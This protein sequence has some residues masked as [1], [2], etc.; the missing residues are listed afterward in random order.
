MTAAN[1][2]PKRTGIT[3]YF[4][5]TT[6]SVALC[7]GIAV[8]G[9]AQP[10]ALVGASDALTSFSLRSLDWFFLLTCSLF[11]FVCFFLA[12]SRYGRLK[13]GPD[14]SKPE[15]STASWIAMLFAAGMGAGL[16]FWGVAEPV[17]H[18]I[19]PPNAVDPFTPAAARQAMVLANLHWGLHAWGVYAMAAL[20]LAYFGFRRG[21]PLLV[22][23]PIRAAFSP[24][25]GR[26]VGGLAEV[27]AILSVAFGVAASL[28]MGVLQVSSGLNQVFG[29]PAR[30]LTVWLIVLAVAVICYM[31]SAAT[32]VGKGIKILSNTNMILA[33]VLLLFILFAGP[34]PFLLSTFITS[35]GDYISSFVSLSFRLNAYSGSVEWSRVWTLTYL[36][37]WIAWGPFVGVFVARIS[38]GRT[39]REFLLGVVFVPSLASALWFSVFG[40]SGLYVEL[41]GGGGI[42]SLVVEDVSTALYGLFD[43]FPLT[44][45]LSVLALV[46]VFIFLVTSADSASFVLGMMSSGGEANPSTGI[47][48]FWG[49]V[50]AV[51][52]AA[53]LIAGAGVDLMKALAITGAI[54]FVFIMVIQMI[55]L[56]RALGEEK[57]ERPG[58]TAEKEGAS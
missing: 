43:F 5:I 22:S 28:G 45:G 31:A 48:L 1:E 55:I 53:A 16:L 32:G 19:S 12:A 54:P 20:V 18:F 42:A 13:L 17:T 23:S 27:I 39:I 3:R 26:I 4:N 6:V 14:D 58:G 50:V 9:I 15:F 2:P 52:A 44:T 49:L 35:L 37:W 46:L 10:K 47:K 41:F 21:M 11:T 29:T 8:W 36:I 40:G 30:S 25:A 56:L 7:S 33:V 24:V 34:T 38:Y 57:V 51:V